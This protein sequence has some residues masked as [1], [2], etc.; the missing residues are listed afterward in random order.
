MKQLVALAFLVGCTD[1][2]PSLF[3]AVLEPDAAADAA[4]T[5]G[6]PD[7]DAPRDSGPECID[8]QAQR[9]ACPDGGERVRACVD[10][11]WGLWGPCR[12]CA[13]GQREMDP[14]GPNGRGARTRTCDDGAW[15]E[16]GPCVDDDE[17]ADGGEEQEACG[18]N[19]DG[20]RARV[21]AEGLWGEW[22]ACDD[23][24]EC[25]DDALDR[26]PCGLNG[27]GRQARVCEGGRWTDLAECE[28]PDECIDGRDEVQACGIAGA[29]EHGRSCIGGRWGAFGPCDDP[30]VACE[31]GDPLD[32][33]ACGLNE[34]GSAPRVCEGGRVALG[35]CD[36]PDLCVDGTE[37]RGLCGLN[38]RGIRTRACAAGRWSAWS[39]CDDADE[40]ADES[41]QEGACGLNGAGA[42]SRTCLAGRWARWSPCDDPD[43]CENG[44]IE[45]DDSGCGINGRGGRRRECAAGQWGEWAECDD[46]DE[47]ADGDE[48]SRVCGRAGDGER[49]RR[50]DAGRWSPWSPCDAEDPCPDPANPECGPARDERCNGIDDDHD[51]E[52]DEGLADG[53]PGF[54]DGF[55]EDQ[56]RVIA[57]G[58]EFLRSQIRDNGELRGDHGRHS[59]LA[60]LVFLEQREGAFAGEQLGYRGLPPEDQVAVRALIA[61]TV[62]TPGLLDPAAPPY[63]YTA[64]GAAMTLAAYLRTGGPDA[65][66][67]VEV[68]ATQALATLVAALKANQG[69]QP[70]NNVGGWNYGAPNNSGDTSTTHFAANGLA[71]ATT[72]LGEDAR[73]DID[74]SDYLRAA[75]QE[76]GGV[77]YRPGNAG[78][79][80]MTASGLW[81][82]YLA[83]T[84]ADDPAVVGA[85]EW[86]AEHYRH[87]SMVGGFSPTSTYYF[88]WAQQ[89]A[90]PVYTEPGDPRFNDRDPANRDHHPGRAGSYYDTSISLWFW[91]DEDGAWG[92]QHEGSPRGWTPLSSHCFALL[93]LMRSFGGLP[94]ELPELGLRPQCGDGADNDGDGRVDAEDP[95]CTFACT[96]RERPVP[97]CG[98]GRD[99]DADGL[100]DLDDPG[101]DD[102]RDGAE[103]NP[104]CSNG[105]DDDGDGLVD[106]P[107]EPGCETV[108]DD[109]EADP[110]A[111]PACGNGLD[112]D[113]DGAADHDADSQCFSA[114][115]DDEAGRYVCPGGA[116]LLWPDQRLVR[117]TLVGAPNDLEGRCGGVRGGERVY[118]LHVDRPG[119]VVATTV[120]ED[121][122]VDTV[123]YVRRA[124]DDADSELV[125]NDDIAVGDPLSTVRF[126]A[127]PGLYFLV[128]DARI[129]AGAFVLSIDR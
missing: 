81:L 19:G 87:D 49:D 37:I 45:R 91:R 3:D 117:G 7:A 112:D 103:A 79:S 52:V 73:W 30:D 101:C 59:F 94:V 114:A 89:K 119:R 86:L 102:P 127:D 82:H 23:P 28:D 33:V 83:G 74:L 123:L 68:T 24:A 18:L 125:C 51:G 98:N 50:C 46:P 17:C 13:D 1:D 15:G 71:A 40:C 76:D 120:H 84:P 38:D 29:G 32:D 47:C 88:L 21:C 54:R 27:N 104:A 67:G 77:G 48:E 95:E 8:G 108:R 115:Q 66:P 78:N 126:D 12:S 62:A 118:A 44:A 36:D 70:P 43:A 6:A 92:T 58:V 4:Q 122:E 14:C 75:Q 25:V 72:V 31:E 35:A 41:E 128:V 97:A 90:L 111:A 93:T 53:G 113:G 110:A 64:G 99:D 61:R 100:I 109:D 80:S 39:A 106:W 16:H 34:R 60:A 20:L 2:N 55:A 107:A 10:D 129:G 116:Q 65:L 26:R 69:Q 85:T 96:A 57:E 124:C 5:D 9:D 56:A 22:G 11:R 42:R 105:L 121:T 63:V